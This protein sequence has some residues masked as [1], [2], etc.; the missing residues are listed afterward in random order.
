MMNSTINT[1][2][3]AMP[4]INRRFTAPRVKL[5]TIAIAIALFLVLACEAKAGSS[6]SNGA[7]TH[8][9]SLT[10]A[11]AASTEPLLDRLVATA[12]E[13][14][15]SDPAAA[16]ENAEKAEII[17]RAQ[18]K[19]AANDALLAAGF[20]SAEQTLNIEQLKSEKLQND[21]LLKDAQKR[22]ALLCAVLAV[23]GVVFLFFFT[24]VVGLRRHRL[25]IE[26]VNE[27]LQDT[28]DQ[29]H[30]EI[31]HRKL[32]EN[33]LVAAKEEAE[34]A[35]RLKTTFLATMSHELRTPLNGILGFSSLLLEADLPHQHHQSAQIINSSG[36]SL[37]SLINDIL[38]LSQ[39][40]AGKLKISKREFDLRDVAE[41]SVSLLKT[42]AKEKGINLALHLDPALPTM[43]Y[44]DPDRIRQV[45]LN[46]VGNAVKFTAAGA[47][48]V[49]ISANENTG[50]VNFSIMDTGA[51]IPADQIN[52][53]F[54]RF[55][56]VD[57]TT[58]RQ[59]GGSGLGLAICKELSE[60]MGGDIGLNSSPGEGSEFWFSLPLVDV[61]IN[62]LE[63]LQGV[64]ET[65]YEPARILVVDDIRIDQQIFALMLQAM[66]AEPIFATCINSAMDALKL[67]AKCGRTV[68]A[69]IVSDTLAEA[70]ADKVSEQL[71]MTGIEEETKLI[72][73]SPRHYDED[74]L[75]AMGY[76]A[77]IE[78]P[79]TQTTVFA[80]LREIVTAEI[81]CN[82]TSNVDPAGGEII[83]LARRRRMP[84]ILIAD[85]NES[86]LRV[87]EAV[88]RSLQVQIDFATDGVEAIKA[89][90]TTAYDVVL[91]DIYMPEMSGF[92]ATQAIRQGGG[93]NAK[94]PVIG[95][96]ACMMPVTDA[97]LAEIGMD[98]YVSKP[99]DCNALRSKISRYIGGPN[100]GQKTESEK[101]A[102]TN[103][104]IA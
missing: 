16:L 91:M 42:K 58:S 47:V 38:D 35:T 76:D 33:D 89:A 88:L 92:E 67:E 18:S 32:V 64:I 55:S 28:V 2:I 46:L 29:L 80:K 24:I 4:D 17:A 79:I 75:I 44:G 10:E 97:E 45:L 83:S 101:A 48:A 54:E 3:D 50:D 61:P 78:Q 86:N 41:S 26:A 66:R 27:K 25:R 71:R 100:S 63:P 30:A 7:G 74:V 20:H 57:G 11:L 99:F 52:N 69:I 6:F 96:S 60:S 65:L 70:S 23:A 73:S 81:K 19:T 39:I 1:T 21:I 53:L 90:E 9:A 95:L 43:A 40:E 84:H 103:M 85:D 22:A 56:Q 36:E 5:S 104:R 14:I 98:G 37:L 102:E 59:H 8:G 87:A 68:D 13:Q 77:A 15:M 34:K 94:T 72:L 82:A 31:S 93:I 51:G 49:I 12:K 62:N